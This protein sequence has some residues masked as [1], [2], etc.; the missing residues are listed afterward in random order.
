MK[1]WTAAPTNKMENPGSDYK[2]FLDALDRAEHHHRIC[3]ICNMPSGFTQ[4]LFSPNQLPTSQS[5][6]LLQLPSPA[7]PLLPPAPYQPATPPELLDQLR[8]QPKL[9]STALGTIIPP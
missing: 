7:Q 4:Y 2:S 5:A 9:A 8:R 1:K 3:A 6:A